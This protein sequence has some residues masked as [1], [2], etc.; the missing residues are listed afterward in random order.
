MSGC[1][2][3]DLLL[4]HSGFSDGSSAGECDLLGGVITARSVN[5]SDNSSYTSTLTFAEVP[6]ENIT[7]KCF[8]DDRE[9]RTLIGIPIMF[10]AGMSY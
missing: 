2:D 1:R 9:N 5:T 3:D 8:Y 4:Q 6:T 7:V 10:P